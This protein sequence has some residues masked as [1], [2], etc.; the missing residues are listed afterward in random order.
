ME[1]RKP[2]SSK[3]HDGFSLLLRRHGGSRRNSL[4]RWCQS[5][6]QGYANIDITNFSS[7]WVDGL[8][9]CAVYHTYLP[10]HIPYSSLNPQDKMENLSLAFQTGESVGIPA[11][12][13]VDEMLRSAGPDW[14]RVLGYVESMYLHFEM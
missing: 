5:R 13:T 14:Q 6:T 12:L 9:F 11:T 7:S 10:S 3:P 4:L 2:P 1:E 8:A